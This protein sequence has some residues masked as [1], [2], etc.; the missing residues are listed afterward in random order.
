MFTE[1]SP[2][3]TADAAL[4]HESEFGLCRERNLS[5]IFLGISQEVIVEIDTDLV[6]R[7]EQRL[8]TIGAQQVQRLPHEPLIL[9]FGVAAK[10]EFFCVVGHGA[11]SRPTGNK[12]LQDVYV[13]GDA[14][15]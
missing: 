10:T 2:K 14:L 11:T 12:R 9:D 3:G 7:F 15:T 4:V 13:P 5:R 1:I 6:R 8:R